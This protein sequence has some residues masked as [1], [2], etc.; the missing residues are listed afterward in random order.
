MLQCD[1][2]ALK[3]TSDKIELIIKTGKLHSSSGMRISSLSVDGENIESIEIFGEKVGAES[4]EISIEPLFFKSSKV[5]F[6]LISKAGGELKLEIPDMGIC[7]FGGTVIWNSFN[8]GDSVG[9]HKLSVSVD[10]R[11]HM[12]IEFDVFFK[13]I[14]YRE[15]YRLI[16][17]NISSETDVVTRFPELDSL[18]EETLN[19]PPEKTDRLF[20]NWCFIRLC[21]ILGKYC[22]YIGICK[23]K[24][25]IDTQE[26]DV[27]SSD[28]DECGK[29]SIFGM[30]FAAPERSGKLIL[31][32]DGEYAELTHLCGG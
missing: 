9:R 19:L 32:F 25:N 1:D 7:Y 21:A 8:I 15:D 30:E 10:D 20:A 6:L 11:V 14:Q 24:A 2:P 4:C 26:D 23:S 17:E 16:R 5:D 29:S 28:S 18:S 12:E 13:R 22:R 27:Q 3:I 31:R